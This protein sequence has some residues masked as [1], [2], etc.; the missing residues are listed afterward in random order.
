MVEI[1]SL[2]SATAAAHH[3]PLAAHVAPYPWPAAGAA[4]PYGAPCCICAAINET[5]W[6]AWNVI[7]CPVHF[8]CP[9]FCGSMV[10][11][12]VL[13]HLHVD[14]NT[15]TDSV[16]SPPNNLSSDLPSLLDS[17]EEVDEE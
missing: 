14:E 10:A 16:Y 15:K 9:C 5:L 6:F 8:L 11:M 17:D 12:S 13:P 4:N 7:T 2:A 1:L 3:F